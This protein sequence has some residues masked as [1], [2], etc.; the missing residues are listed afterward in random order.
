[1]EGFEACACWSVTPLLQVSRRKSLSSAA[2]AFLTF[3]ERTSEGLRVA[4]VRSLL[5]HE[6]TLLGFWVLDSKT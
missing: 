4:R 3:G 5:L 2:A 1:M 6:M